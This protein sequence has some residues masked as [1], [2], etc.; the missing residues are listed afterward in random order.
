MSWLPFPESIGNT[1]LVK[2]RAI[3]IEN[4][5]NNEKF[6]TIGILQ[7]LTPVFIL[8]LIL[9]YHKLRKHNIKEHFSQKSY[10][11]LTVFSIIVIIIGFI[12]V[13]LSVSQK[14][15]KTELESMN[16]VDLRDLRDR[17]ILIKNSI[18][19]VLALFGIICSFYGLYFM[20][21]NKNKNINIEQI[22]ILFVILFALLGGSIYI[23]M[24]H[25]SKLKVT[26]SLFLGFSVVSSLISVM[27]IIGLF[28]Y[29]G[30]LSTTATIVGFTL[31]VYAILIIIYGIGSNLFTPIENYNSED[32]IRT[33]TYKLYNQSKTTECLEIISPS[34]K[35][36]YSEDVVFR[37]IVVLNSLPHINNEFQTSELI[38]SETGN[39][40][41][42]YLIT[43]EIEFSLGQTILKIPIE[44]VEQKID[45][46]WGLG[47][48]DSTFL[49]SIVPV[50]LQIKKFNNSTIISLFTDNSTL[51]DI[52]Y[53]DTVVKTSD[54][55][56]PLI[57]NIENLQI[58]NENKK[59]KDFIN[60]PLEYK[61][62]LIL[63]L[64]VLSLVLI[65]IFM[66]PES[67]KFFFGHHVLSP[68]VDIGKLWG[69]YIN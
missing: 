69:L 47:I 18:I 34:K 67:R 61:I 43:K 11:F 29:P 6:T 17:T 44:I 2:E 23:T 4:L 7:I 33:N 46:R 39:W 51:V 37:F 56:V 45:S 1:E 36:E 52:K 62:S 50:N 68:Q 16:I 14:K 10:I 49:R 54:I 19:I 26:N 65:V 27:C 15:N 35:F 13:G 12:V 63:V 32:S 31:G 59:L 3:I 66:P 5:E 42:K 22:T 9:S 25:I 57:A 64:S 48:Q 38:K 8:S 21:I 41:I 53:L 24:E 60:L 40:S 58:C 20:F 30:Q 55:E 28:I